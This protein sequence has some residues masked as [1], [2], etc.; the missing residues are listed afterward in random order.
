MQTPD[1]DAIAAQLAASNSPAAAI[2]RLDTELR[3]AYWKAKDLPRVVAMGRAGIAYAKAQ[4][5]SARLDSDREGFLQRAKTLAYNVASFTWP[6]WAE[7]GIVI[8]PGD[9]AFGF[10]CAETNLRLAIELNRPPGRVADAHWLVGAHHLG[11]HDWPAAE[12]SFRKA[13]AAHD[14]PLMRGYLLLARLCAG[15]VSARPAWE[16]LLQQT[17]GGLDGVFEQLT[18]AHEVFVER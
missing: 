18:T 17:A 7:F 16:E 4:A 11:R 2:D 13:I 15:D 8:T 3:D 10:E 6:G 14:S 1:A 5:A 12:A 9:L